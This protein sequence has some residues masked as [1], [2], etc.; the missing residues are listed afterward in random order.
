[1][2]TVS[3]EQAAQRILYGFGQDIRISELEDDSEIYDRQ[4]SL[5]QFSY[6]IKDFIYKNIDDCEALL[7]SDKVSSIFDTLNERNIISNDG[8]QILL[9]KLKSKLEQY[10][11]K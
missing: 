6:M 10:N 8:L 2:E 9:N 7:Y 1:M 5:L 3:K 4:K 11:G